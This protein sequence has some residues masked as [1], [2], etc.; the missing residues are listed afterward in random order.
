[1]T[2]SVT[3]AKLVYAYAFH[4]AIDTLVYVSDWSVTSAKLESFSALN[5]TSAKHVYVSAYHVTSDK[6][7]S[8]CTSCMSVMRVACCS[9]LT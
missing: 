2:L 1:M 8:L 6:L 3:S 5:V 4:V 9:L 7:V